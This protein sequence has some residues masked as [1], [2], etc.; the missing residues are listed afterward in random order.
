MGAVLAGL[1]ALVI[2]VASARRVSRSRIEPRPS[3]RAT[4]VNRNSS[5][6]VV[7]AMIALGWIGIVI[8]FVVL[9]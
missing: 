9:R 2:A 3:G 1:L 8:A 6:L 4:L 7:P 5:A